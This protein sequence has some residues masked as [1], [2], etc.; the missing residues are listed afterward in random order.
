MD[1]RD[2]VRGAL[3]GAVGAGASWEVRYCEVRADVEGR[4]VTGTAVRYG[5]V[6]DIAGLFRES[7]EPGAFRHP[8]DVIL[9]AHHDA[10]QP[11]AR[12][13]GGALTL[14]DTAQAMT[15]RAVLPRTTAADDALAL[16]AAGVIRGA[17]VEMAVTDDEWS[18]GGSRRIIRGAV[19]HGIALVPRPA[20]PES[21]VAVHRAHAAVLRGAD[22]GRIAAGYWEYP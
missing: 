20:Y 8:D 21:S 15:F 1:T 10:R 19:L 13:G 6:A 3:R 4:T 14:T 16:M 5:D 12:A 2:M 11:L 22:K 18:E 9:N 17:S 7:I